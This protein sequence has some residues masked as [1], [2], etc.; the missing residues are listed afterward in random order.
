MDS[1][2]DYFPSPSTPSR[3]TRL[4]SPERSHEFGSGS[5]SSLVDSPPKV[6]RSSLHDGHEDV[7]YPESDPSTPAVEALRKASGFASVRVGLGSPKWTMKRTLTSGRSGEGEQSQGSGLPET[8][9]R[10]KGMV[11][12]D[13][14]LPTPPGTNSDIGRPPPMFE[15]TESQ[16]SRQTVVPNQNSPPR[17]PRHP[18]RP[19]SQYLPDL[20]DPDSPGPSSRTSSPHLRSR[21][22]YRGGSPSISQS[23]SSSSG[24]ALGTLREGIA[25][26]SPEGSQTIRGNAY[27]D[28]YRPDRRASVDADRR[29]TLASPSPAQSRSG[30]VSPRKAHQRSPSLPSD[31]A[32]RRPTYRPRHSEDNRRGREI[33]QEESAD[34]QPQVRSPVGTSLDDRIRE[35]EEKIKRTNDRRPRT[36][37]HETTLPI[38]GEPR[39]HESYIRAAHS[40]S[41]NSTLQRSATLSS[42]SVMTPNG[43][44][45]SDSSRR[46][47]VVARL[48]GEDVHERENSGGSGSSG[49][50][51]PIPRD[52]RNGGLVS[53]G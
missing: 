33:I 7:D 42:A 5:V 18:R 20:P 45:G 27:S 9:M 19:S 40:P 51:K 36:A 21:G 31:A 35:A 8:S 47:G 12:I 41:T 3:Q 17:P 16:A 22:S 2:D 4:K 43:V 48:S 38:S 49:R 14:G 29:E 1:D 37:G 24:F 23:S 53:T 13:S 28:R 15:R 34:D 25:Q 50:R 11:N 26:Y 39:R 30:S 44:N 52:F 46:P 6:R 10:G 32:P